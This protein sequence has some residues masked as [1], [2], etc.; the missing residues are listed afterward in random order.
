V[1]DPAST[2]AQPLV[3][4]QRLV[5]SIRRRR[6]LWLSAALLGLIA[7][8]LLSV[9]VPT[10]PT[11]VAKI[12]VIHKEDSPTDSGT[13]IRT[14]V[15]V[16]QTTKI[17]GAAL[18]SLKINQAPEDFLKNYT[19]VGL[20]NNVLQLTVKGTSDADAVARAKALS[21]AFIADH[22][23]QDKAAATAAA[24]ALLDQRKQVQGDLDQVDTQIS[25]AGGDTGNGSGSGGNA[26]ELETLYARRAQLTAQVSDLGNQAQ[27]AGTGT[28]SV[29]AGTQVVDAAR[30]VVVS[31]LKTGAT[32]GLIGLLVGLALGIAIAAVT[33]VIRDRPVLRREIATHLGA[34]VIGQLPAPHR[35]PSRLWRRSRAVADRKRVAVTLVRAIRDAPGAVSLLELGDRRTTAALALDLA[36]ELAIDGPVVVVDD[37]PGEHLATLA[38][39]PESPIRIIDG[40][41]REARNAAGTGRRIGVGSVAPG[42]AWTDLTYLGEETLLV[43]RAGHANTAWLHTVARQ[44]ADCQIRRGAGRPGPARPLGRHALGRPAHRVARP[45]RARPSGP[46]ARAGA[47]G[48]Q[49]GPGGGRAGRGQRLQRQRRPGGRRPPDEEVRPGQTQPEQADARGLDRLVLGGPAEQRPADQAVRPGAATVVRRR[50]RSL[51][52]PLDTDG[53]PASS[54]AVSRAPTSGR[55]AASSPT[56]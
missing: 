3:D 26:T 18:K 48:R 5:V 22:V 28:P 50:R 16:L 12:L 52:S 15:A 7:G 14:D 13:L 49:A 43:V 1:T 45:G 31:R 8:G 37:L 41:D 25:Q 4:L 34:S 23:Q 40:T 55:T 32:D 38:G 9:F 35:G 10:P 24:Q 51:V 36:E 56:G 46:G 19:S 17:A 11:A 2:S 47:G 42:T 39:E 21:E 20:T 30:I 54:C 27:A 53:G 6:R 44:L 29:A 33:G